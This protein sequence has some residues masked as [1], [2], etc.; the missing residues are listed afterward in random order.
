MRGAMKIKY[1]TWDY[2]TVNGNKIHLI[3]LTN[4]QGLIKTSEE[5]VRLGLAQWKH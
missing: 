5:M 4:G 1:I 2:G 3:R